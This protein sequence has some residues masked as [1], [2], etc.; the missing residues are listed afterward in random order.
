MRV[1]GMKPYP[2]LAL[3]GLLLGVTSPLPIWANIIRIRIGGIPHAG[4][5][6][7]GII[8]FILIIIACL[9]SMREGSKIVGGIAIL[10][11]AMPTLAGLA[12]ILLAAI[13]PSTETAEYLRALS[14]VVVPLLLIVGLTAIFLGY[15]TFKRAKKP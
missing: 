12:M 5:L 7:I 3:L 4:Q 1:R 13:M 15:K 10:Y 9:G 14:R 11:G 6:L 2:L 8:S